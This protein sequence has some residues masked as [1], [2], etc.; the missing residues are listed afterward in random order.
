[1]KR[2]GHR[3]IPDLSH[4]QSHATPPLQGTQPRKSAPAPLPPARTVKPH[5]TSAKSGRR[6][7]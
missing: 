6:G 1:M 2:K 4:K 7:Q 5:A 3:T